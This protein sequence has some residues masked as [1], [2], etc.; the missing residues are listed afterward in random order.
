MTITTADKDGRRTGVQ[1]WILL[2]AFLLVTLGVGS[3]I[4]IG[5][6]PGPW[7]AALEKPV[8]NPPNWIFGP[9]WTTLYVMIAIAGWRTLKR[10]PRGTAMGLWVVQMLLN[11]CWSPVFFGAHLLWPAFGI[12]LLMAAGILA[13]ILASWRG[14]RL[15]S[16]LMVPYLA[17]VSFAA[18][19]NLSLAALNS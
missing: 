5:F 18:V 7:Y 3:L 17:W 1:G 15:S 6:R 12:I 19:L 13:F 9:V 8:F 14:D 11:W 10:E 16:F 4:G 2:A